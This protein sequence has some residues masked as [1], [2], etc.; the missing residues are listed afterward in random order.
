MGCVHL[1]RDFAS[2]Q[3]GRTR[4]VRIYTPDTDDASP[5]RSFPVLSIQDGKNVFGHPESARLDTWSTN[6]MRKWLVAEHQVE[7]WLSAVRH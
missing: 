6:L 1:F 3:E 2:P 4:T 5:D 7:A